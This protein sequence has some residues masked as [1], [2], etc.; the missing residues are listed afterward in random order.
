MT[1]APG[2]MTA[3][4]V[5][6]AV[7]GAVLGCGPPPRHATP[8]PKATP[9]A[10]PAAAAAAGGRRTPSVRV[11]DPTVNGPLTREVVA[12]VLRRDVVIFSTC[13]GLALVSDPDLAGMY[14]MIMTIGTSGEV[15]HIL[16]AGVPDG[17][18]TCV[19]RAARGLKFP[20]PSAP[21]QVMAPIWMQPG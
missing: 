9:A 19:G 14:T 16:V 2:A 21:V 12:G 20:T 4:S 3:A 10:A 6:A 7:A 5:A 18:Q 11:L 15:W 8:F 1:A 13:Y 17:L